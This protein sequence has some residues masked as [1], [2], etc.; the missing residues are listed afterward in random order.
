MQIYWHFVRCELKW[1][2]CWDCCVFDW[3]FSESRFRCHW[4]V[5]GLEFLMWNARGFRRK[6]ISL[7]GHPQVYLCLSHDDP[8]DHLSIMNGAARWCCVHDQLS[9]VS[10]VFW[11]LLMFTSFKSRN[12]SICQPTPKM[13]MSGY[14]I[15]GL[16]VKSRRWRQSSNRVNVCNC[17]YG[18]AWRNWIPTRKIFLHHRLG[19]S[20]SFFFV[21]LKA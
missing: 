21:T 6:M 3:R 13:C 19:F 8:F 18:I 20:Q 10:L 7:D 5:I 2:H 17:I 1:C 12:F 4:K 11:C 14:E 15:R 9:T 16:T